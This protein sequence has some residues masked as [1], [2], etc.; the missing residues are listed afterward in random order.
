MRSHSNR[1]WGGRTSHRRRQPHAHA[2]AQFI[3]KIGSLPGF[4]GSVCTR[5]HLRHTHHVCMRVC[6]QSIS[7]HHSHSA[8]YIVILCVLLCTSE[9]VFGTDALGIFKWVLLLQHIYV[10]EHNTT[11]SLFRTYV[12]RYA[13]LWHNIISHFAF[14]NAWMCVVRQSERAPL[15]F[16]FLSLSHSLIHGCWRNNTESVSVRSYNHDKIM[17]APS[18]FDQRTQ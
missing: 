5:A 13:L 12:P 11:H 3:R 10:C 1:G 15:V 18:G 9:W 2:R 4:G 6:V 7:V 16:L 8:T 17:P 14:G